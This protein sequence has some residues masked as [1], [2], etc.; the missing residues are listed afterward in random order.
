MTRRYIQNPLSGQSIMESLV[1]KFIYLT[2][3][4]HVFTK[5]SMKVFV[6]VALATIMSTVAQA[7]SLAPPPYEL[8]DRHGVNMA[9]GAVSPSQM[10]LS[11]GGS[12]G[13][14][15]TISTFTSNFLNWESTADS[16]PLGYREQYNGGLYK[17][18]H[19][20]DANGTPQLWVM[21]V[22]D[23][24]STTEFNINPDGLTFTAFSDTRYTLTFVSNYTV[25]P[26]VTGFTGFVYTKPDGTA[27]FYPTTQ[28]NFT[29]PG[30]SGAS[31]TRVR[32]KYILRANGLLITVSPTYAYAGVGDPVGNVSTNT[33]FQLK[34]IYSRVDPVT[35]APADSNGPAIDTVTWSQTMPKYMVGINNA[36]E[37]CSPGYNAFV[38]NSTVASTCPSLTQTWPKVT[39][40]WPDGMP[41]AMY[42][43][44]TTVTVTDAMNR[45]TE[46]RHSAL[47][48]G[49]GGWY[50]KTPRLTQITYANTVKMNYEYQNAQYPIM[51]GMFSWYMVGPIQQ[52]KG[53]WV[54]DDYIGYAIAH[55]GPYTGTSGNS[56]GAYKAIKNVDFVIPF[57]MS[58]IEAWDKTITFEQ[59]V[60]NRPTSITKTLGG[61]T[62]SL[63]Y[64][65]FCNGNI[66]SKTEDSYTTI[67]LGYQN[68]SLSNYKTCNQAKSITDPNGNVTNY[69]YHQPSGQVETVTAPAD[70]FGVRPQTRYTYEQRK[71]WY[72]NASGNFQQDLNPIWLLK[73]E[74]KCRTTAA[75]GT[76]CSGGATD[77]V[78]TEYYY[79]P[80]SGPNNLFLR[81]VT[82]KAWSNGVQEARVTCYQYDIYGN[83]IG[84]TKPKAGLTATSCPQ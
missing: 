25:A 53:S 64:Y 39:Y 24:G 69:T 58:R 79:G 1:K 62:I 78:T 74:S 51:N 61:G 36:V 35:T 75:S 63:D 56:S 15:H 68:C 3:V 54:A 37:Y 46:Y 70:K 7:E 14:S 42:L 12:M 27:V 22:F 48:G 38:V 41:R 19:S 80:D 2:G 44:P 6:V 59:N 29:G 49:A 50:S 55:G 65:Q 5:I 73:E 9:S 33:G 10:D 34:Y 8:M 43:G 4:G 40:T 52:L 82:V 17:S 77:K 60:C 57:G 23:D 18:W 84:E 16:A 67:A 31:G 20:V 32:M 81:A 45:V 72:K 30:N 28:Q 76:E 26:G 66:A 71:A 11:I 83:K 21:K 13:L 47:P